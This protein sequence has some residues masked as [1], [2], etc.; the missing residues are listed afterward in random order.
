[1][2]ILW[3]ILCVP[4]SHFFFHFFSS[5][6]YLY[7]GMVSCWVVDGKVRPASTFS[8]SS[9]HSAA[10]TIV[11]WNPFGKR[12]ITGDAVSANSANYM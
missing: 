4:F 7:V 3:S 6:L 9:Q 1:M 11:K 8:N 2:T 5:S 12:L 10:I